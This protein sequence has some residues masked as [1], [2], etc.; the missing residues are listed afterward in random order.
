MILN[1][2][3]IEIAPLQGRAWFVKRYDNGKDGQA[4][5]VLGEWTCR[6]FD[7]KS[8]HAICTCLTTT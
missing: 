6:I 8:D 4:A 2:S 7:A 5:R 3:K 1:P